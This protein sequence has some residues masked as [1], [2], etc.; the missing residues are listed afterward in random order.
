MFPCVKIGL[1]DDDD[2]DDDDDIVYSVEMKMKALTRNSELVGT[3]EI[4]SN[5]SAPLLGDFADFMATLDRCHLRAQV[6]VV[7]VAGM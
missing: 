4:L 7:V 6:V 3:G 2:D 1:S 5:K